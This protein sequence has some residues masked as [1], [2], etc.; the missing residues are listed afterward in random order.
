MPAPALRSTRPH[1]VLILAIL[2]LFTGAGHPAAAQEAGDPE[3][4]ESAKL[5]IRARS[6]DIVKFVTDIKSTSHFHFDA[7]QMESNLEAK[8]HTTSTFTYQGRSA[9]GEMKFGLL[10]SSTV[11]VESSV[12]APAS[13]KTAPFNLTA[14]IMPNGA[15]RVQQ[16]AGAGSGKASL[17]SAQHPQPT[18][19]GVT[20]PPRALKAGDTW[21]GTYPVQNV[22][23][24]RGINLTYHATLVGFESY[25][26]FPSARVEINVDYSGPMPALDAIARKQMPKGYTMRCTGKVT[27]SETNYYSLDRG[28]MLERQA[29]YSTN[30]TFN[31]VVNG[32]DIELGGTVD[33]EEHMAVTARPAYDKSLAQIGPAPSK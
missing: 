14:A 31:V 9:A 26:G 22:P 20:L 24:L 8:S 32:Q 6:G 7:L 5:A 27:G 2:A 25:Q 16:A 12:G 4:P 1:A 21:S 19:S 13:R 11:I 18:V 15:F 3:M 30:A 29:R 33:N 10:G 23:E 28:W 17:V